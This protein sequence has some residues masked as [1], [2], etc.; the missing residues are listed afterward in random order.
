VFSWLVV[1]VWV[2]RRLAASGEGQLGLDRR[3]PLLDRLAL[4]LTRLELA[5][6]RRLS[7]PV[8]T[9]IVCVAVKESG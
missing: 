3:S 5:V 2:Q 1:P 8:G 4:V 7:L 9:S 6:V